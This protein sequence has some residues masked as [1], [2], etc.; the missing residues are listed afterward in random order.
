[1]GVLMETGLPSDRR[2]ALSQNR[3]IRA[4]RVK[5][6]QMAGR[7]RVVGDS[8]GAFDSLYHLLCW[9]PD[10]LVQLS[11]AAGAATQGRLVARCSLKLIV[12]CEK[13]RATNTY[14]YDT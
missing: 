12:L 4:N 3:W 13:R 8:G 7:K 1:L 5:Q 2:A 6:Q 11:S 14:K 10:R 9:L